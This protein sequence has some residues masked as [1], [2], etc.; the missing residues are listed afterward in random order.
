MENNR[1]GN[2]AI[3]LIGLLVVMAI[4]YVYL[5]TDRYEHDWRESWDVD[6][7]EPYGLGLLTDLLESSTGDSLHFETKSLASQLSEKNANYL[8]IGRQLYL[9][10]EETDSLLNYVERGHDAFIATENVAQTLLSR[11]NLQEFYPMP[12]CVIDSTYMI[13]TFEQSFDSLTDTSYRF[14]YY[15]NGAPH[16]RDWCS[17]YD[18]YMITSLAEVADSVEIL[19][20]AD[21]KIGFWRAQWGDGYLYFYTNPILFTNF[22]VKDSLGFD[23]ARKCFSYL[24]HK[25]VYWDIYSRYYHDP[26]TMKV[27]KSPLK[28]I[29]EHDA[30]RYAWYVL[31][32]SAGLFLLFRSK[33]QQRIQPIIPKVENTSIEFAKALG[34]LYYQSNSP[35][36]LAREMMKQFDNHNRRKYGI[37]K[38]KG[39]QEMVEA[40]AFKAKVDQAIIQRIFKLELGLCYNKT[41]KMRDI[42]ALY[43]LLKDYYQNARK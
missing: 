20:W 39:R 27:D 34:T 12:S 26:Q 19:G 3:I 9:T 22:F 10:E 42:V 41:S 11:L 1:G 40:I 5:S 6:S 31:L 30:L 14:E 13:F 16:L 29:F 24:E 18:Y 21:W 8:F 7:M 15:K 37:Q 17:G 23:H 2:L 25:P 4:A 38:K 35:E 43:E 32:L 33:R 28:F 36:Y